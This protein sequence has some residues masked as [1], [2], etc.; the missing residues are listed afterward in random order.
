MVGNTRVVSSANLAIDT[1]TST[2][3]I[4]TS[5]LTTI[6]NAMGDLVNSDGAVSCSSVSQL[7]AITFSISGN[8]FTLNG[9]DYVFNTSGIC[10]LSF[11]AIDNSGKIIISS[12]LLL[13]CY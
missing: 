9:S 11:L 4:P 7:P 6:L 5:A 10:S 1:G 13:S 2:I 8:V 3:V 12:F